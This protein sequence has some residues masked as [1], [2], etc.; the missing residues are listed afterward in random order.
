MAVS[1]VLNGATFIASIGR[2]SQAPDFQYLVDAAFDDTLR[3]GRFRR[4]NPDLGFESA[5]QF[6]FSVRARP[7]P[8]TSLRVNVYMKRLDG[9]VASVPL[10]LSP[11]SSIFGNGDFGTVKGAEVIVEREITNG[12]GVRVAYTLQGAT[13]TATS[14]FQILRRIRIGTFGDTIYPARVEFPLDY[15]RRHGLLVIGQAR[16]ND[17]AGPRIGGLRPFAG[18]EVAAIGRYDSG[19]PYSRTNPAGDTLIGLPNS[20]R[21]PS[22]KSLDL[23]VRQPLRVGGWRGGLYL[24]VR[25][26]FN[27]R[28]VVAVRRDTGTPG[29]GDPQ[30]QAMAL[31]AYNAHPE[32]IPYESP[33]Y[34]RW[35]DGDGNGLIEGQ[36]ELMPLY[37][38]AATDYSQPVFAYGPPRLF[39]LGMELVF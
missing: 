20:W 3:T 2:F 26:L 7:S 13:A 8:I 14:A 15:D 18:L 33:R 35:A 34:R 38:A 39:R 21:L 29:A 16:V 9:L 36:A 4:G 1:T 17:G 6:E 5:T 24:D 19:L 23:L 25:N 12:I 31:A 10:G 28:N 11:D 27:W 22:E 30:I 37:L 32:A